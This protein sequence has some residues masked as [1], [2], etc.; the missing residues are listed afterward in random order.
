[1][2]LRETAALVYK[3]SIPRVPSAMAKFEVVNMRMIERIA[4][5]GPRT[6]DKEVMTYALK[7]QDKVGSIKSR[8]AE[9]GDIADL[10][11]G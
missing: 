11:Q 2:L 3:S 9:V 10:F 4:V 1:M 8:V 6:R 5:R 7:V